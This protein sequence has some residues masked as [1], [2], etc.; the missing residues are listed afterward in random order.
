MEMAVKRDFDSMLTIALVVALVF[1]GAMMMRRHFHGS[2]NSAAAVTTLPE[3]YFSDNIGQHRTLADFKGKVVL[4][5]L[6]ATWCPPCVVEL[7]SLDKLQAKLKDKNFKVVAIS[8]NQPPL[9]AVTQFLD[10]KDI[11]HLEVYW[12]A[13][14]QIPLKWRYAGL[15][16]SFLLDKDGHVVREFDG[17]QVWDSGKTFDEIGGLLK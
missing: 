3:A 5:N 2:V 13:D 10:Q 7:P 6:W 8:M 12:D 15:P 1:G 14:R 17:P 16:A 11:T 9:S 4:V